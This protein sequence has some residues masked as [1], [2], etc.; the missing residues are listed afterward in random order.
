MLY[1]LRQGTFITEKDQTVKQHFERWLAIHK[2]KI[3]QS[4]YLT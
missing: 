4:T 3:R 1:E 2:T